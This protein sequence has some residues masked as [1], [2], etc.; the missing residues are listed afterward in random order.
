MIRQ[1]SLGCG[2]QRS[3]GRLH[4]DFRPDVGC[5]ALVDYPVYRSRNQ[6]FALQ[7]K[8]FF[9]GGIIFP[10][11]YLYFTRLQMEIRL[12]DGALTQDPDEEDTR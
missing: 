2:R 5:V 1:V 12:Y 3:I 11:L 10:S 4:Y 8:Q 6:E 9:I 7:L